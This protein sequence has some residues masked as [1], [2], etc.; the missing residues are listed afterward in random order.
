MK[1]ETYK[2]RAEAPMDFARAWGNGVAMTTWTVTGGHPSCIGDKALYM[3]DCEIVFTCTWSL[4]RIRKALRG[5]PD[6]HVM[7]QTVALLKDYTGD[8][9]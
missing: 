7:A 2:M 6:G 3:G 9:K 4:D 8:R 5:V 1:L